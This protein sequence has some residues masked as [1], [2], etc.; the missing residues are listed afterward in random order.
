[1]DD[2]AERI[3]SRVCETAAEFNAAVDEFADKL[4][5]A[6]VTLL[7]KKVALLALQKIVMRTPVDTGRARG[8]WQTTISVT[9]EDENRQGDPVQ[10][11]VEMLQGLGV[12]Q[13]VFISNNVPYIIYLE[14][15]TSKQAPEGMVQLTMEELTGMFVE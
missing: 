9:P 2:T 8:N 3:N 11:G 10:A 12:F 14:D 15:G 13:V 4:I 6:Q 5:P 1:V 7:Q